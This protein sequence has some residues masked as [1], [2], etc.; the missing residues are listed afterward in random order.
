MLESLYIRNFQSHADTL[1]EFSPGVT[2]IV[3]S[4]NA[5]KTAI[6][7]ALRWLATNR[8]TGPGIVR[9]GNDD[10]C[11]VVLRLD[12]GTKIERA[13][14]TKS[15]GHYSLVLPG[16]KMV[17]FE[18]MKGAV[19]EAVTDSLNLGELNV[20]AQTAGLFLVLDSPGKIA[21]ALNDA[22][23]LDEAEA[24]ASAAQARVR[25]LSAEKA[26]E[27]GRAAELDRELAVFAKLPDYEVGVRKAE[28][29]TSRLQELKTKLEGLRGLLQDIREVSE[30]IER[31]AP[32]KELRPAVAKAEKVAEALLDKLDQWGALDELTVEIKRVWI[33][34]T[35]AT[36][37]KGLAEAIDSAT[38]LDRALS[39]LDREAQ[40]INSLLDQLARTEEVLDDA[41]D[42]AESARDEYNKVRAELTHCP[43]C[44]QELDAAA[45]ERMLAK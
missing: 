30:A 36:P 35:R 7:R 6:L 23:H 9:K 17:Q 3:G 40:S 42:A 5:G 25:R 43:T 2:V 18:A 14:T 39:R 34:L 11:R 8:P 32:P 31:T 16:R 29:L 26:A 24:A 15:A 41:K 28:E 20:Q 38:K 19:P 13:R 1:V 10:N 37:P 44:G 12:D 21:R 22:V 4:S 27:Q 45:K 33:E